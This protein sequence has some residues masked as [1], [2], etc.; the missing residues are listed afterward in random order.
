MIFDTRHFDIGG[1]MF[2]AVSILAHVMF[3]TFVPRNDIYKQLICIKP[4]YK[5]VH[6]PWVEE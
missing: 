5:L 4:S 2:A 6:R 3:S 1:T